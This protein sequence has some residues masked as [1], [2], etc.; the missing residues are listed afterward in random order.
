MQQPT[1]LKIPFARTIMRF[2][3]NTEV[4]GWKRSSVRT[5]P[6]SSVPEIMAAKS[7]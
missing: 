5:G 6:P 3:G 2:A 7:I 4:G 1:E